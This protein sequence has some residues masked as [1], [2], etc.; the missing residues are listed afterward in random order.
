MRFFRRWIFRNTLK[1]SEI[2]PVDKFVAKK[3]VESL[4]YF[5][6]NNYADK[7]DDI[8]VLKNKVIETYTPDVVTLIENYTTMNV[9][10]SNGSDES[11]IRLVS[12][13]NPEYSERDLRYY[14]CTQDQ[15]PV[16][17]VEVLKDLVA[18]IKTNAE[19]IDQR[20]SDFYK[21]SCIQLYTD[22]LNLFTLITQIERS[23][24]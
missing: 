13:L 19:C 6:I 4:E 9:F 17:S 18:C 3:L 14:W 1:Y 22:T 2:K 8:N 12:T 20:T 15:Y 23:S 21:R 16:D 5:D 11:I 24:T 7:L 10:I